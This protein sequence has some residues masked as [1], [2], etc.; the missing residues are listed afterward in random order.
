MKAEPRRKRSS[1]TKPH[2]G[3]FV[4]WGILLHA[5]V[6][7]PVHLPL[8]AG[9]RNGPATVLSFLPEVF[10]TAPP[11]FHF[12]RWLLVAAGILW[13]LQ[14][15]V[16]LS[17]WVS[18]I[19][20]TVTVALVFENSTQI[21]HTKNL[22]NLVLFVHAMWYHF[23]ATNICTALT[24]NAFWTSRVYPKWIHFLSVFC[25]AIYHS[26][27]ALSKLLQSGIGWPNGLSLQLWVHLMGREHSLV[28]TF[29]LSSRTTA[30]LMQW[31][32]LLLEASSLV[33]L[34]CPRLRVPI[35]V[36]LLG[37]YIGIA[38]SFGFSFA[39]NGFLIAAFFFPWAGIIDRACNSAQS[40][41]MMKIAV[42]RGSRLERMLRVAIPRL[43]VLGVTRLSSQSTLESQPS[44]ISTV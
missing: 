36:A 11:V 25:I 41:L 34:F 37:L 35:G 13:A 7:L 26:N 32:T 18:V 38:D 24:R 16:P 27:A 28:N 40:T 33:A 2:V 5:I 30:A 3:Q 22:A 17:S 15:L 8:S 14:L 6:F 20:Y 9:P 21:D 10:L 42:R 4:V 43:D 29:I 23:D 31:A 44:A 39:L 12:F 19:A 1:A